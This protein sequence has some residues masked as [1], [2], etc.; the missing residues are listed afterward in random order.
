VAGPSVRVVITAALL[1]RT[2]PAAQ[3]ARDRRCAVLAHVGGGGAE[4]ALAERLERV[5]RERAAGEKGAGRQRGDEEKGAGR[6]PGAEED[7]RRT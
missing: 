7:N 3:P 1:A 6:R 4:R 5:R 2:G